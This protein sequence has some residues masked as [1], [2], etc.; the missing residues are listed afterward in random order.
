MRFVRAETDDHSDTRFKVWT[1][2][3][4][5]LGAFLCDS[6]SCANNIYSARLALLQKL[7]ERHAFPLQLA[8]EFQSE[9][10]HHLDISPPFYSRVIDPS[11]RRVGE[12]GSDD[13]WT[14]LNRGKRA[15]TAESKKEK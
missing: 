13:D 11:E 15:A 6:K 1:R 14:L 5:P 4:H 2:E 3:G 12:V 9:S 7:I 8:S 10:L